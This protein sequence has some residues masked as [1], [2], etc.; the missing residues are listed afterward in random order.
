MSST[1]Y[2]RFPMIPGYDAV[3]RVI[4]AADPGASSVLEAPEFFARWSAGARKPF[5]AAVRLGS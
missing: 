5:R 3:G 1:A 4:A 2:G